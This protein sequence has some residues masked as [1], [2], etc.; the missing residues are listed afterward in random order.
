MTD[1]VDR[2]T[3]SRMMAGIRGKNTRPEIAIR[4]CLFARGFRYRLHVAGLP[5][6]PDL[7]LAKHHAAV[8]VHGCFWHGHD[9]R[10]FRMPADN[11]PF[12]VAK[13]RRNRARDREV[14]RELAQTG[15]R[16]LVI[17]ECALHDGGEKVR[18]RVCRRAAVWL[19]S[20]LQ[21]FEIRG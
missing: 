10:L 20:R 11:R 7:V 8:F 6:C 4:R 16:T 12:W 9:C 18:G 5:G 15:W 17:W 13:I 21:F 19:E 3:R 2:K 1:I 14:L